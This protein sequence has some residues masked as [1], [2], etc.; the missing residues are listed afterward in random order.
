MPLFFPQN[1]CLSIYLT[2]FQEAL[3]FH[4][5][6]AQPC[7][8]LKQA[9]LFQYLLLPQLALLFPLPFQLISFL[10][11]FLIISKSNF[12]YFLITMLFVASLLTG[13]LIGR[14]ILY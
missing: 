7:L 6:H 10:A 5:Q 8:Y 14:L 1:E 4:G 2:I 9:A 11:C 12:Y 13:C 3:S